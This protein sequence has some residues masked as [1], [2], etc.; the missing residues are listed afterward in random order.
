MQRI[1][2]EYMTIAIRRYMK[3]NPNMSAKQIEDA[4]GVG[5]GTV[6][7]IIARRKKRVY[8]DTWPGRV[9]FRHAGCPHLRD[10]RPVNFL[11]RRRLAFCRSVNLFLRSLNGLSPSLNSITSGVPLSLKCRICVVLLIIAVV[12]LSQRP[13]QDLH[14]SINSF[15]SLYP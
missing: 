5:R 7:D 1:D 2:Y 10:F 6:Y 12:C 8:L 14:L 13:I 9:G 4:A 3:A 15:L 11:R